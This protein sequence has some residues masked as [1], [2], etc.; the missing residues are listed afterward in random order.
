MTIKHLSYKTLPDSKR[1]AA[2]GK[3][4]ADAQAAL[5]SPVTSPEQAEQL[6]K[7][8]TQLRDWVSGKLPEGSDIK[9]VE[10]S[11][12]VALPKPPV[13]ETPKDQAVTVTEKIGV[14]ENA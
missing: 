7:H 10:N 11:Q 12:P 9:V 14:K 5:A 1:K 6:K 4:I 3:A 2:A 8:L 13:V